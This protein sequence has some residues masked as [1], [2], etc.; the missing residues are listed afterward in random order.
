[1]VATDINEKR[2]YRTVFRWLSDN[3]ELIGQLKLQ[4]RSNSL[5]KVC[6]GPVVP[7]LPNVTRLCYKWERK[8]YEMNEIVRYDA[9]LT[10]QGFSQNV[11]WLIAA[12][13]NVV[14]ISPWGYKYGD[15]HVSSRRITWTDSNSSRTTEH[16][17]MDWKIRRMWYTRLRDNLISQGYE[18]MPLRVKLW[19]LIPNC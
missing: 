17:L 18:W 10:A 1:M 14:S 7:T 9:R 15:W 3:V 11:L 5:T 19:S 4:S 8:R 13:W 16:P 6:L 2:R 12:L